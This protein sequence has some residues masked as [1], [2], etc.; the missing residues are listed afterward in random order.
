M[1]EILPSNEEIRDLIINGGHSGQI[2]SAAVR[3]GFRP[4]V[5]HGMEL[6]T[7][8]VVAFESVAKFLPRVRTEAEQSA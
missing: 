4:M 5:H 7:N 8:Q 1:A 2:L 6:V 3:A